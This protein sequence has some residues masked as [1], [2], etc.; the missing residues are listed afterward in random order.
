MKAPQ[1]TTDKAEI[2]EVNE[3]YPNCSNSKPLMWFGECSMIDSQKINSVY[4]ITIWTKG[5]K[6][7]IDNND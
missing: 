3:L 5:E 2:G 6:I 4:K 7:D 1:E